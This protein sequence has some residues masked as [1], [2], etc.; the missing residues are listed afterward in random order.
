MT[1][2]FTLAAT[3]KLSRRLKAFLRLDE[4]TEIDCYY[5]SC[6]EYQLFL[7]QMRAKGEDRKPKHWLSDR[8]PPGDARKPIVG[9]RASDA[10]AFCQWLTQYYATPGFR[11][12][13]M[14]E[15]EVAIHPGTEM[16][17]GCWCSAETE[18]VVAGID[19]KQWQDWRTSLSTLI[20]SA[21]KEDWNRAREFNHSHK[22]NSALELA[23]ECTHEL[24]HAYELNCVQELTHTLTYTLT[25]TRICALELARI[26]ALY[27]ART[28]ARAHYRYRKY[29]FALD[30]ARELAHDLDLRLARAHKIDLG[31]AQDRA[32]ALAHE[33]DLTLD[34]NLSLDF[35]R[36][37]DLV[38][39]LARD[40]AL[41]RD[42]DHTLEFVRSIASQPTNL[43]VL[44]ADLVLAW[45][46]WGWLA[47]FYTEVAQRKSDSKAL[48]LTYQQCEDIICECRGKQD[49]TF[50]IYAF[51]VLIEERRA[52]RM[53]A[54]EGIRI[55]RERVE[56]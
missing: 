33:F 46:L 56:G 10:E 16:Q 12:R 24:N 7:D 9:V 31:L 20:R 11:Y 37:R 29:R 45:M 41:A 32:L 15:T 48:H 51:V 44:R 8:F 18:L 19:P 39:E 47:E 13:L 5:I 23:L 3:V 30:R 40:L 2:R 1:A 54:W 14:T 34:R 28:L 22:L 36:A 4:N 53:P 42:F 52:G 25:R 26:R 43:K 50:Q 49:K 38:H 17:V 21:I 27:F 55:V 6:A 35:A